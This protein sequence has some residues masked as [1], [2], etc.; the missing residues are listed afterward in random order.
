M[1]ET[2]F[3]NFPSNGIITKIVCGDIDLLFEGQKYEMLISLKR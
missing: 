1:Q 3:V 2:T